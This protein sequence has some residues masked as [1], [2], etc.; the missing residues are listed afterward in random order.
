MERNTVLQGEDECVLKGGSMYSLCV[1]GTL[2]PVRTTS[3]LWV[4]VSL[5]HAFLERVK[6]DI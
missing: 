1:G 3:V 2:S 4:D 5:S 6:P